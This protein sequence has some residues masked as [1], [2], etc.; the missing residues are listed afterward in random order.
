MVDY[1]DLESLLK[2]FGNE[3][4]TTQPGYAQAGGHF[5][6][7]A[8]HS[9]VGNVWRLRD[10]ARAWNTTHIGQYYSEFNCKTHFCQRFIRKVQ[11]PEWFVADSRASTNFLVGGPGSGLPFHRHEQ[12]F[13]MLVNGR[14]AWFL[15]PPGPVTDELAEVVGPYVFPPDSFDARIR[16]KPLGKRPL[17]CVQYPGEVI[18]LP[19]QW[20]HATMNMGVATVAYG[21]KPRYSSRANLKH[22]PASSIY[23]KVQEHFEKLQ[24]GDVDWWYS[25]QGELSKAK[26]MPKTA[27]TRFSHVLD[28]FQSAFDHSNPEDIQIMGDTVAFAYCFF[29]ENLLTMSAKAHDGHPD[30]SAELRAKAWAANAKQLSPEIYRLQCL[31]QGRDLKDLG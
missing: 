1:P 26:H 23:T 28:K 31:K 19:P 15:V 30:T 27:E 16:G 6:Y 25:I 21:Q 11:I 7:A 18:W 14:K 12:T 8:P 9:R 24:E 4:V 2:D 22:E 13:Q 17:R 5:H 10:L 20:W 3:S 29:S